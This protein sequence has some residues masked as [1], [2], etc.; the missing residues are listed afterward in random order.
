[1][2]EHWDKEKDSTRL[3]HLRHPVIFRNIHDVESTSNPKPLV[4]ILTEEEAAQ[5]KQHPMQ[6]MNMNLPMCY[7]C[8]EPGINRYRANVEDI[9][10]HMQEV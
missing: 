9:L 5:M 4:R 8:D 1:M 7:L 2:L 6:F 3:H 10:V